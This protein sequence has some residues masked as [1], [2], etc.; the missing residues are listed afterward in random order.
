MAARSGHADSLRI[1][2]GG[3]ECPEP[4]E[5]LRDWLY[6]VHARS[7]VGMS[8]FAPLSWPAYDAW[9]RHWGVTPD[10]AEED[11]LF[12]LD[13]IMLAPGDMKEAADDVG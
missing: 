11:A 3:P 9:A 2:E 13:G 7:G 5:Y 8:G 1:L 12:L 4:L 6:A 10:R